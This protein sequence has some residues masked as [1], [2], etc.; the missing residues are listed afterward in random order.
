M[1]TQAQPVRPNLRFAEPTVD[2]V[3]VESGGVMPQPIA[4]ETLLA[5]FAAG[6]ERALAALAERYEA[7]LLGLA[8]GLLCRRADLAR[9][10]VQD[11]WLR[12]MKAAGRFR[13][14]SQF[15]TW[16][17]RIL[18]N[19]CHDLR[20]RL[21]DEPTNNLDALAH[22]SEPQTHAPSDSQSGLAN[23]VARLPEAQQTI[24]LL[25]YHRGLTHPQAAEVL[26]V[27]LGTL[28]SRL[29]A[30]LASLRASLAPSNSAEVRP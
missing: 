2:G 24:I 22:R 20:A 12:V 10:A 21:R 28:K 25:C 16:I 3:D 1:S 5:R 9:D 17:Y 8:T 11:T 13:G 6:D 19:R 7:M 23:I 29:N 18:I 27:P 15:K 26:G 14:E 30:A 4:D